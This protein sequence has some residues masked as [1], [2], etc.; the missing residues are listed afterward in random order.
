M[1]QT[2]NLLAQHFV[3]QPLALCELGARQLVASLQVPLALDT[4]S[5]AIA[6]ADDDNSPSQDWYGNPIERPELS[7]DGI[8]VIPVK[9]IVARGLGQLGDLLGYVD[10][11]KV[12]ISVYE[13]SQN[14]SV[15]GIMLK[16]DSPGGS[17]LGTGD[18]GDA[19]D[20]AAKK[21]PVC[22]YAQGMMCS[23]AYWIG[24]HANSVYA[25]SSAMIGSIGVYTYIPD[26]TAAYGEIG[27]KFEL[28]RSG[29]FKGAGSG[30]TSVEDEQRAE[31]QKEIDA[32]GTNFRSFV[33][34]VRTGISSDDMEGQ[35]YMGQ[36]A[37]DH[38]F[39]HAIYNTFGEALAA[40]KNNIN[41]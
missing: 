40:F 11:D 17:V 36:D 39:I 24:S 35:T 10:P 15:R 13:A 6:N 23:A 25:G 9:G 8:M 37:I 27:I 7:V 32:I 12:A 19:V 18:A 4:I 28:I 22:V 34:Q 33:S 30:L 3:G 5:N 2:N 14:P 29:K 41:K 21:K 16:I 26:F 38:G 1:S 31:I 20:S